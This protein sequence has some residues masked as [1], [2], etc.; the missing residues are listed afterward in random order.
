MTPLAAK[1][2]EHP[3]SWECLLGCAV[4][5]LVAGVLDGLASKDA[6]GRLPSIGLWLLRGAW[7]LLTTMLAYQGLRSNSLPIASPAELLN[8]RLPTWAIAG[9]T[10]LCLTLAAFLGVVEHPLDTTGKPLIVIHVG[11]AVLAYCV[12]GAQALNSGAYLLQDRA[13]ARHHFGGVYALL[14]ALVPLDR[15]GSQ[16]MGAAVWLLGLSLVIG[17]TDWAQR[18]PGLVAAP[19]LIAAL[20]TWLACFWIVVQRRRQRLQGASFA[21]ASL[22]AA[23][24]ALV[25]LYLSLPAAR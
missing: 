3:L 7:V 2:A 14:P 18:D 9:S 12:L 17:T 8:H 24:P 25:A 6:T 22:V 10:A 21:R 4:V 15:I 16:L 20:V 11:A 23:L 13:L 19:K 1:L 5:F